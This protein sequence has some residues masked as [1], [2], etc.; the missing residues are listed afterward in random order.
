[1]G[2]QLFPCIMLAGND[3]K[4]PVLGLHHTDRTVKISFPEDEIKKNLI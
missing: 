2:F 1:M 4:I 3:R